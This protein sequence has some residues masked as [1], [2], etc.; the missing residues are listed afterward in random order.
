MIYQTTFKNK[1]DL[2]AHVY[3]FG[4]LFAIVPPGEEFTVKSTDPLT[5]F[6][7][8]SVITFKSGKQVELEENKAWK[9]GEVFS[10]PV[11]E[12][13]NNGK[14]PTQALTIDHQ[15][16]AVSQGFPRIVSISPKDHYFKYSRIEF[17]DEEREVPRKDA[18]FMQTVRETVQIR[19]PRDP[20]E[21]AKYS[22]QK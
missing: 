22:E 6:A 14:V 11:I 13:V 19:T 18:P 8:W 12:L 3:E 4:K 20:A 10:G 5:T 2:K 21:I 9:A 7:R 16:V 17:K 1:R 15:T